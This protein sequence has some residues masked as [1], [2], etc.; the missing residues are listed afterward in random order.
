M[1]YEEKIQI[2][3]DERIEL[4][5]VATWQGLALASVW[6]TRN[7]K[8]KKEAHFD[9]IEQYFFN[10]IRHNRATL[11]DLELTDGSSHR[12][13]MEELPKVGKRIADSVASFEIHYI[14]NPTFCPRD[15]HFFRG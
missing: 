7:N 15:W 2:K 13:S 11:V 12:T 9:Q 14:Y 6:E 4:L 3:Q 8:E 10:N 1:T 5:S